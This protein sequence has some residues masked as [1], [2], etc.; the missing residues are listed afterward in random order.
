ML[1]YLHG[2]QQPDGGGLHHRIAT[3]SRT[4]IRQGKPVEGLG[5][6]SS[7]DLFAIDVELGRHERVE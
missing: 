5:G 2:D 3:R 4:K 7:G 6:R 1:E